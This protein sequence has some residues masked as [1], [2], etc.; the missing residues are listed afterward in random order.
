MIIKVFIQNEKGSR[1]RNQ[2]D[3]KTLK[4]IKTMELSAS[5]RYQYGFIPETIGDDGDGIDVWLI[6]DCNFSA[7]SRQNC[8]VLGMLEMFEDFGAE[9][10]DD[11]K[12]FV[13]PEN[14]DNEITE[15]IVSEIKNFTNKIFKKFPEVTVTFGDVLPAA[16]AEDFIRHQTL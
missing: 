16:E 7:G 6:S 11:F 15:G 1:F 14:E 5:A 10:Q 9:H 2:Y 4:Y 3:E 12:V 13:C 8:R